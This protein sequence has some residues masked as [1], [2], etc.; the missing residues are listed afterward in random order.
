MRAI[1]NEVQRAICENYKTNFLESPPYLKVGISKNVKDGALPI[2]GVRYHPEG[3]TTGWYLWGGE[4]FSEDP[5]FFIP[6]HVAHID[7][8]NPLIA[9]YLGLPPGWRFL[10]TDDYEDVWFDEEVFNTPA[11]ASV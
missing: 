1:L 5:D 7:D 11:G 9:K 8:C 3:D 2:N 10:V 6:L 4:E